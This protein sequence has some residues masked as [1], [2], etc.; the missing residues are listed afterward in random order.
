VA[1]VPFAE[2]RPAGEWS[3]FANGFAGLAEVPEPA[4]AAQR[5]CGLALGPDGSLYVTDS[6]KGTVWRI[7]YTG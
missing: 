2:G 6:V 4:D 7:R 3:V 1:F 5:P